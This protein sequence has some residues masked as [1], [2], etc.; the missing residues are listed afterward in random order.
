[1]NPAYI[2][3]LILGFVAGLCGGVLYSYGLT[4]RIHNVELDNARLAGQVLRETKARAAGTRWGGDKKEETAALVAQLVKNN[5]TPGN[6]D[7][8]EDIEKLG[9]ERGI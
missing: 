4:R 2:L 8:L 9:R 7:S 1:M 5:A 6:L 3:P